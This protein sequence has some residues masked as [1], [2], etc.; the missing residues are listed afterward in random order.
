[1]SPTSDFLV[2]IDEIYLTS[3]HFGEMSGTL[4]TKKVAI[5][6][7]FIYK[8]PSSNEMELVQA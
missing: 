1:M 4:T 8:I 3:R 2:K 7:E 6:L 5:T